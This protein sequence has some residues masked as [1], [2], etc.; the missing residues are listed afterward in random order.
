[1]PTS[2][3]SS[4]PPSPATTVDTT[5]LWTALTL[6]GVNR[7]SGTL[8]VTSG[9]RAGVIHFDEGR[10]VHAEAGG[11]AGE[12]AF[13]Q[14]LR[15]PSSSYS[16]HPQEAASRVTITRGLALLLVDARAGA[17]GQEVAPASGAPASPAA[18]AS[19]TQRLVSATAQIRRIPDVLSAV[20]TDGDGPVANLGPSTSQEE[21]ALALGRLG[22]RLGDALDLGRAVVG[23]AQGAQRLVLLLTTKE[24][25][26]H[27][28]VSG[29]GQADV[30]QA[31]IR[32]I[33]NPQS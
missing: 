31:R 30:V 27:I 15:W 32:A 4:P 8:K 24:H 20:L 33:I 25:Q 2:G 17:A 22:G 7:Y 16:L 29:D 5:A 11:V 26:L 1:M 28:L 18:E 6:N 14:I 21:A 12:R 19:R 9:P 23:V 10:V 3:T 13:Q